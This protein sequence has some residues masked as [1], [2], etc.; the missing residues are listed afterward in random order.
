MKIA[1]FTAAFFILLGIKAY[2]QAAIYEITNCNGERRIVTYTQ[3]LSN[4]TNCLK[5]DIK[6]K[7]SIKLK[8]SSNS[9]VNID[10]LEA[11][12]ILFRKTLPKDYWSEGMEIA[13]LDTKP[14]EDGHIWF[15]TVYVDEDSKHNIKVYAAC[16]VIYEGVDP[17]VERF[18]PRIRTIVLTL[19][20]KELKKYTAIIKKLIAANNVTPP[21]T[22][23]RGKRPAKDERPPEVEKLEN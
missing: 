16:K 4:L 7:E 22:Q 3:Q 2:P 17:T 8:Y 15:E 20:P 23:K 9:T 21:V 12:A 10:S 6:F 14:N 1:S 19:D 5:G 18:D 13:R 11:K